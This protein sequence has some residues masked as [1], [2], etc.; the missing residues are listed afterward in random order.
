[1]PPKMA[2][3]TLAVAATSLN[4]TP[5]TDYSDIPPIRV[6][7]GQS[8]TDVMFRISDQGGGIS[9][10]VVDMIW[11]FFY[12]NERSK[13]KIMGRGMGMV[14]SRAYADYWGG[15]LELKSMHGYGTDAYVKI[16]KENNK[17]W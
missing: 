5:I 1:M 8:D 10:D 3:E 16:S 6:T 2:E 13:D 4:T 7:I 9:K 14:I 17:E 15:S 12:L 11:S